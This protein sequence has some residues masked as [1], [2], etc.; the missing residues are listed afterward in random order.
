MKNVDKM[1]L[2]CDVMSFVLLQRAACCLLHM[3]FVSGMIH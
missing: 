2:I 3:P 1:S